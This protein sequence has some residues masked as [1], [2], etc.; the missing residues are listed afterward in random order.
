VNLIHELLENLFQGDGS[1]SY[2]T[3][4]TIYNFVNWIQDA[5]GVN[6]SQHYNS[7]TQVDDPIT[8]IG[9]DDF[10]NKNLDIF[11]EDSWK[12]R[13]N[14]LLNAG[15]RYDVQLVP[16][17]AMPNTSSDVANL[18]TKTINID[19][20]ELQPRVG[21]SWQP[22]SGTVVR[23]GYGLFY[24]L[25]SNSTYYTIRV[26]NG[27]FQQQYNVSALSTAKINAPYVPCS[28]GSSQGCIQ[29]PGAGTYAAYAPVAPD[30]IFTPPGPALAAPFAGAVTPQAVNTNP[31]LS[32]LSARGLDPHFLN[33]FSHEMDLTLEQQ[34]PGKATFTL[35]WVA[36]RGMRLPIFVDTNLQPA[37]TSRTYDVVD[38]SGVTKSTVT[39]PFYTQRATANTGSILTGFSSVNSW[40]N[41]M[42]VTIRRPFA[43]GL[44]ILANFTWAHALDGAQVS[45]VN[46]TFNGTDTPLDPMNLH[47]EYG[48]SDLDMRGRF[49]GTLVYA[50]AFTGI[51]SRPLRYAANGWSLSGTAT[52]QTGFPVTAFMG[53]SPT[54]PI[55]NGGVT[56]A[57]L[58]LNNAGTPGRAPQVARNG[59]PGPGLRNIDLRVE[60]NFPIHEQIR[61]QILGEAFNVVNHQN[62]LSVNTTAFTYTNAGTG[63]CGGHANGCISPFTTGQPFGSEA[64]TSS[65][66]YGPRQ[67]QFAAKLFF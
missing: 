60:R 38:T 12:L 20:H 2:S 67:L 32:V 22:M 35:A 44:E 47:A 34:I 4:Q 48:R 14:F 54:S 31:P 26:E 28:A 53:N 59:F 18:Y 25:T 56:G 9:K 30:P 46:G 64:S 1:F 55:G 62:V 19:Y 5:Y 15:L 29:Q 39:V 13:P 58:S 52:E 16:Q 40:Y 42:V 11:A 57:E 33:P 27:V 21:F 65:I 10:W 36:N 24:G 23:G 3:G 6:G 49:V 63:I 45:G 51:T 7:F 37:T 50:P 66:L 8:H 61:F 43:N 41:S 17:P